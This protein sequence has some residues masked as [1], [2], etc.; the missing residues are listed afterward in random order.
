MNEII[1]TFILSYDFKFHNYRV[2]NINWSYISKSICKLFPHF[3]MV[4]FIPKYSFRRASNNDTKTKPIEF[5][6]AVHN[7][8]IN[9][10]DL[11]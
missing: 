7:L 4:Q 9:I 1:D 11:I 6:M 3:Y 10:R 5:S 2:Y 8:P